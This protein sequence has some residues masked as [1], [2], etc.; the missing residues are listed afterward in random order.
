LIWVAIFKYL[1]SLPLYRQAALLD[2]FGSDETRNTL[3]GSMVKVSETVPTIINLLRDHL[4]DS[5]LVFDD[6]TVIHMTKEAARAA[7]SKGYLWAQ[8]IGTG[9]PVRLFCYAPSRGG[10]HAELLYAGIHEGAVLMFDGYEVY[11]C[12]YL[13]HHVDDR[14]GANTALVGLMPRSCS[15]SLR[16]WFP[17]RRAG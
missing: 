16:Q 15:V 7:Q 10:T 11:N 5:E 17:V 14:D 6:E 4:L 13:A 8:M 3:A 2:R 12:T 1:D 9:P